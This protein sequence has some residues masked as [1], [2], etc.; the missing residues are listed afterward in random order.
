MSVFSPQKLEDK[1]LESFLKAVY[2]GLNI[3]CDAVTKGLKD[4]LSLWTKRVLRF[5]DFVLAQKKLEVDSVTQLKELFVVLIS[6]KELYNH[7]ITDEELCLDGFKTY[8]GVQSQFQ[9]VRTFLSFDQ[10]V[11]CLKYASLRTIHK[12]LHKK[13]RKKIKN[14]SSFEVSSLT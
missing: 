8:R 14:R 6:L 5:A 12:E 11:A 1:D 4:C 9:L 13:N 10:Y 3:V 2:F 7:I